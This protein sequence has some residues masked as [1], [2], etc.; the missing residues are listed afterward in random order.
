MLYDIRGASPIRKVV[1]SL[2]SNAISWNPMEPFVFVVAN[3]DY[4]SY[5]FDMRQL[6][7]PM[8]IFMDHVSAVIDVD[9]SPTGKEIVTGSYDKTIRI[10]EVDKV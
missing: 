4:N 1:L 10:F 8:N 9:Y 6:K 3:E 5:L 7:D 2:R